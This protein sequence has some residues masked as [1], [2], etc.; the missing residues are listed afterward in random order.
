MVLRYHGECAERW[1]LGDRLLILQ[2]S[3]NSPITS[4]VVY[5]LAVTLDTHTHL[6]SMGDTPLGS[7]G[8]DRGSGG[9]RNVQ[10][11]PIKFFSS[12]TLLKGQRGIITG[13]KRGNRGMMVCL[14]SNES[15]GI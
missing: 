2:S 14:S 13:A 1:M 7:T 8:S 5:C 4:P 3:R 11:L 9:K 15:C 10:Q 12:H 6:L